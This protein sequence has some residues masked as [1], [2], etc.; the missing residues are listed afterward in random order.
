VRRR[1]RCIIVERNIMDGRS[2]PSKVVTREEFHRFVRE[3]FG[4]D[5]GMMLKAT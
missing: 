3:V 1:K 5:I 2:I 4:N